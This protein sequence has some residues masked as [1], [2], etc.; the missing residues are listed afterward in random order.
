[1]IVKPSC[2]HSYRAP[3]LLL[4]EAATT[5][6]D[7]FSIGIMLARYA[8]SSRGVTALMRC[9]C[10]CLD[11]GQQTFK[12]NHE[13][14]IKDRRCCI[15]AYAQANDVEN[16]ALLGCRCPING[17]Y[18]ATLIKSGSKDNDLLRKPRTPDNSARGVDFQ[19][20]NVNDDFWD[21][22]ARRKGCSLQVVFFFARIICLCLFGHD[23]Q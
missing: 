1:M 16:P 2:F 22:W 21:H 4:N 14:M 8:A 17:N 19:T 11:L 6:A 12:C 20:V 3:E 15:F 23:H 13:L 18:P 10:R 5:A 9:I 7:M